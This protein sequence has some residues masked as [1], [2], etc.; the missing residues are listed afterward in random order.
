MPRDRDDPIQPKKKL[1]LLRRL[2][3]LLFPIPQPLILPKDSNAVT[4]SEWPEG[5]WLTPTPTFFT[6]QI[7]YRP[8]KRKDNRPIKLSSQWIELI[9]EINKGL[10]GMRWLVQKGT[11]GVLAEDDNSHIYFP[12][13]QIFGGGNPVYIL[14]TRGEFS[15]IKT[16][17]INDPPPQTLADW[18]VGNCGF[19][20]RP[21]YYR[22]RMLTV[23]DGDSAWVWNKCL[24]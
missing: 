12:S 7:G 10:P 4:V 20:K 19:W 9:H 22:A 1:E 23:F 14:E 11:S 3:S 13:P 17:N 18:M 6:I 15:R 24:K 16:L 2:E 8:V 5:Y 21:R